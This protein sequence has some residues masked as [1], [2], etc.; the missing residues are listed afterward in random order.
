MREPGLRYRIENAKKQTFV[1]FVSQLEELQNTNF[2]KGN[3]TYEGKL[4]FNCADCEDFAKAAGFVNKS[5]GLAVVEELKE[6]VDLD[7]RNYM[8]RE[9]DCEATANYP[10]PKTES[11]ALQLSK[12]PWHYRNDAK[13]YFWSSVGTFIIGASIF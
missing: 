3:S 13:K 9:L 11:G 5:A 6:K 2:L 7:E 10:Y 12:M 8:R 4:K 1:G